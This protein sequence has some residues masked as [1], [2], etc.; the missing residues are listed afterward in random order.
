M[1]IDA[2]DKDGKWE[3][4]ENEE[5]IEEPTCLPAEARRKCTSAVGATLDQ[6]WMHHCPAN[7]PWECAP[8]RQQV[9]SMV[10]KFYMSD[11]HESICL[12]ERLILHMTLCMFGVLVALKSQKKRIPDL[13]LILGQG[14]GNE[15]SF[16]A[17]GKLLLGN[18]SAM[19]EPPT[20]DIQVTR[21]FKKHI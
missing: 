18:A 7:Y 13:A 16:M 14:R 12:T 20:T 9:L 4:L 8:P 10:C 11:G 6:N 21:S 5:S 2:G 1:L 3:N 15:G 19:K 17:F